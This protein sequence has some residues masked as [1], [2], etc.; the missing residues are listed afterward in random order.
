MSRAANRGIIVTLRFLK[1]TGWHI[2]E[3]HLKKHTSP[4]RSSRMIAASE[5][6]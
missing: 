2:I 4:K 1:N 5:K 3:G 6:V